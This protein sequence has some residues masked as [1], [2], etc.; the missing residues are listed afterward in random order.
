MLMVVFV[1]GR[2]LSVCSLAEFLVGMGTLSLSRRF[3]FFL[4]RPGRVKNLKRYLSS[5]SEEEPVWRDPFKHAL[6]EQGSFYI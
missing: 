6:P 4:S 1:C 2:M 3:S 5:T